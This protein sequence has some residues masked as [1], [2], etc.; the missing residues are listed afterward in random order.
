MDLGMRRDLPTYGART[1][2]YRL[3][4]LP[5]SLKF[6]MGAIS[7]RWGGYGASMMLWSGDFGGGWVSAHA[8]KTSHRAL[9]PPTIS[10]HSNPS[11]HMAFCNT[12]RSSGYVN[13]PLLP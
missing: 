2:S 1:A 12:S 6:S 5:S 11:L 8:G 4:S 13:G 3:P 7:Q 9:Q 10:N